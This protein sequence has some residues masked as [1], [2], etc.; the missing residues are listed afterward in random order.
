[1]RR[2]TFLPLATLALALVAPPLFAAVLKVN[3]VEI[4]AGQLAIAKFK[5]SIEKPQLA[6]DPAGLN[7]AAVDL[8]VADV[9]LAD[10]AREKGISASDKELKNEIISLQ[11]RL[12]GKS[13]YKDQLKALGAT[14][15]ELDALAARRIAARRFLAETVAPTVTVTEAE[16]RAFYE[17]PENQLYRPEQLHLRMVLVNAP[18]GIG[19]REEKKALAKAEEAERRIQAGDDFATVAREMSDDMSKSN[20]GDLGWIGF[21]AIPA[22]HRETLHALEPGSLSGV[23]RGMFGYGVF[24]VVAKRPAGAAPFDE[25]RKEI[26][27]Q[28]RSGKTDAAA[29]EIVKARRASARIEGLTPEMAA[30]VSR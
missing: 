23:L 16:A 9:L 17:K 11:A 24:Q 13:V 22:Q 8:L 30:A 19:E 14:Q 7:R 20:G 28:L 15:E 2:P 3:S 10:A 25:T 12:G 21:D 29:A 18:P 27:G 5:V 1:M 26:E 6:D 4:S